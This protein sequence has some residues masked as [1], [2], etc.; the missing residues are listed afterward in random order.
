MRLAENESRRFGMKFEAIVELVSPKFQ[1]RSALNL[2][3]ELSL[4]QSTEGYHA[5]E[6]K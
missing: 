4:V 3:D 1:K 2:L 6:A 5:C